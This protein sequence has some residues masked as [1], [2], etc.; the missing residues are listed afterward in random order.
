MTVAAA[1]AGGL[2]G[3]A[4]LA[5]LPALLG[6]DLAIAEAPW[7]STRVLEYQAAVDLAAR[8]TP[9]EFVATDN[10]SIAVMAGRLV[11]PPLV[12][13]SEARVTSGS[14]DPHAVLSALDDYQVNTLVWWSSDRFGKL[15]RFR[16]P[17]EARFEPLRQYDEDRTLY[18]RRGAPAAAAGT[19]PAADGP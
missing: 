7:T 12:D 13:T 6:T 8:T 3:L 10:Q 2:A 9:D 5:S 16:Q 19:P 1:A 14:L 11:P 4:Y 18:V 17:L 15:R